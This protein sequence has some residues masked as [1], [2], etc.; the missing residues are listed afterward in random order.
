MR[1]NI[2]KIPEIYDTIRHDLS[3]NAHVFSDLQFDTHSFMELA[4]L[5]AHFV[6]SNEYGITN[7]EKI[8]TAQEI[9][10]PLLQKILADLMFWK[11]KQYEDQYWKYQ[12]NGNGEDWKHIRTRLY[13]TSAS[14]IYSVLHLLTLGNDN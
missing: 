14:H 6:V 12:N 2:S 8:I 10:S 9:A 3:K 7:E 11:V 1:F 5:I 4:K 13:F